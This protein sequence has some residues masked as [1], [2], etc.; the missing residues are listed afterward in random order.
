MGIGLFP[1]NESAYRS[2]A[3]MLEEAGKNGDIALKEF[4]CHIPLV[5]QIPDAG[6][7]QAQNGGV[8]VC[9]QQ[10]LYAFA[11]HFRPAAGQKAIHANRRG[12]APCL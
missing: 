11:P 12:K 7:G 2:A 9:G 3:S 8:R 1:H 6:S 10:V 4:I 5:V